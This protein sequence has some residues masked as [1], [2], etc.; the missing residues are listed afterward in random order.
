MT[1]LGGTATL[2][3]DNTYTGGTT[4]SGGTLL[5]NNTTGSGTGSGAVQVLSGAILG[6]T[7]T[8][9]GIV[10]VQSGG[11]LSPGTVNGTLTINGNLTLDADSTSKFDVDGTTVANDT[12]VL[13]ANVTYGG[14]LNIVPAGTFSA[15][16]QFVL[17]SGAG[18]TNAGNF[19]SITG[20][21]GID[22]AFT[23]TNGVLSV[24]STA[25]TPPTL[26]VAQAGNTLTFSWSEAGYKLIGQTNNLSTGLG[27]NWGDVPGGATS[28]VNVDIDPANGAAFFGLA[29]Q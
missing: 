10:N 5:V 3:G 11:T 13:G 17:F 27:T 6:G 4:V 7:G 29:P 16:Q 19:A 8:V 23:F 1:N 20:S 26:N 24:Y 18:A 9:G 22:R 12:V 28:P 15:G 14:T 21:P 25:V 2:T